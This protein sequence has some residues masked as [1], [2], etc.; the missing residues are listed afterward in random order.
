MHLTVLA[1]MA[2][3]AYGP[4]VRGAERLVRLP[5]G[6]IPVVESRAPATWGLG[7]MSMVNLTA[8]VNRRTP[9]MRT[10]E[11]DART[12][13]ILSRIGKPGLRRG[14]IRLAHDGGK[15]YICV[16][17]YLLLEV[18]PADARAAK[19]DVAALAQEWLAQVRRVLP[20][21]APVGSR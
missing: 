5:I 12:V 17:P 3:V 1:A 19:K 11:W 18:T 6:R 2:V 16:G 7:G 21:V 14:Q 9:I 13:E 4:G 10:L 20:Q 8:T 15:T